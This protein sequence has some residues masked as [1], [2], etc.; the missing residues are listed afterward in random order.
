[1]GKEVSPH[2]VVLVNVST[3]DLAHGDKV[4]SQEK[5]VVIAHTSYFTEALIR[6]VE[7]FFTKEL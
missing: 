5:T 2:H 4:I 1:M 7:K 6:V 3:L